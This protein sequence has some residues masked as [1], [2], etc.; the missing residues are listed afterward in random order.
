MLTEILAVKVI[1]DS[2]LRGTMSKI[3]AIM[4]CLLFISILMAPFNSAEVTGET[5]SFS[6]VTTHELEDIIVSGY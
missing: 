2:N 5:I 3:L 4:S 1:Y 6:S